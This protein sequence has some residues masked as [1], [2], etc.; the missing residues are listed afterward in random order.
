MSI[1][2]RVFTREFKL[3]VCQQIELKQKTQAQICRDHLLGANLV[4]RWIKEYRADPE[5]CFLGSRSHH[6]R[7][8]SSEGDR[9]KQLEQALGRA[10]LEN[11]ILKEANQILQKKVQSRSTIK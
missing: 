1:K 2:K 8:S 5:N 6:P 11:Q 10:T 7:S 9:I 4:N 3:E